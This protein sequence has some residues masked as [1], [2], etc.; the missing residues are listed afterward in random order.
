MIKDYRKIELEKKWDIVRE[1]PYDEIRRLTV[2]RNELNPALTYLD[3]AHLDYKTPLELVIVEA[4]FQHLF[5]LGKNGL[6]G[7]TFLY[8]KEEEEWNKQQSF[9]FD[10][11]QTMLE[12]EY[13]IEI[14]LP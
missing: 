11:P 8:R 4:E 13:R 1:E 14:Y 3:K 10:Y 9:A 7:R 5:K 12:L 2:P 6:S